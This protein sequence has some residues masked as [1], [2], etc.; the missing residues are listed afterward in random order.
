[1]A[2]VT[3]ASPATTVNVTKGRTNLQNNQVKQ[4][5]ATPGM[6]TTPNTTSTTTVVRKGKGKGKQVSTVSF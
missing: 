3:T 4:E 1:M 6:P 2:R 5:P